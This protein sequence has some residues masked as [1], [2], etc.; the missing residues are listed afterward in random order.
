LHPWVPC[1]KLVPILQIGNFEQEDTV[2]RIAMSQSYPHA[3]VPHGRLTITEVFTKPTNL[4]GQ[5]RI[6]F[7]AAVG[8]GL[9]IVFGI[10]IAATSRIER[11]PAR[12]N[13]AAQHATAAV[14][15]G[16]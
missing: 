5:S 7:F 2:A 14:S 10:A 3:A 12:A 13:V 6:Y 11:S 15:H 9:G 16:Y 1:A 8:A 4:L